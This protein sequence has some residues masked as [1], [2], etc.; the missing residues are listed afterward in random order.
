MANH[1]GKIEEK[2]K[3]PWYMPWKVNEMGVK[4]A[5]DADRKVTWHCEDSDFIVWFPKDRNP[6][7]GNNE[8][9]STN[10][11][12]KA[13]VRPYD[14]KMIKPGAKFHYCILLLD[15]EDMVEGN[16]PPTMIIE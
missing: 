5:P 16:S 10:R 3:I 11:Q 7:E 6:L 12:A 4:A 14:D 15:K 1:H 8:I 13:T 2:F 9:P